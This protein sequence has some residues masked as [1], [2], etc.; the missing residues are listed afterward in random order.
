MDV[1]RVGITGGSY[2]GW[3]TVRAMLEF[4]DFFKVGIAG[5]PMGS[6]HNMYHDY[7]WTAFHGRPVYGDGGEWRP[8]ATEIPQ[9][10]LNTDSRRQA[11][12]LSGKLMIVMGE[13]DENVLPG[14][15]LQLVDAFMKQNK[16]FDLIYLP[17][18]NH[19][20]SGSPYVVRRTWDYLVHHLQGV[21]PPAGFK[22]DF[23][24]G[25]WF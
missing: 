12:K 5:V 25:S 20:E 3:T 2:G 15:T 13:L 1:T 18:T 4:P 24:N 9:N 19:Y 14:S 8:A 6:L 10:F 17:D 23:P 22:L 7:H 11:E 16:D 21:E